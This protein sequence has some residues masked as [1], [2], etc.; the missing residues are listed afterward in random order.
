MDTPMT[1]R[2]FLE[3]GAALTAATAAN[4]CAVPPEPAGTLETETFVL[5]VGRDASCLAFRDRR[6]GHDFAIPG[7]KLARARI[8][9]R[10][11]EAD[12]ARLEGGRLHLDFGEAGTR[13]VLLTRPRRR[14]LVLEVEAVEGSEWRNWPLSISV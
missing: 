6:S 1:R 12:A 4:A 11:V 3:T 5:V 9:G 14:S 8:K 2:L 10:E 13:V 7:A